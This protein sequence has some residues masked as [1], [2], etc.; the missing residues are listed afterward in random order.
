MIGPWSSPP[1][2]QP[3]P[4][5]PEVPMG[6]GGTGGVIDQ[7]IGLVRETP[8]LFE[9]PPAPAAGEHWHL[10][11]QPHDPPGGSWQ[12][13]GNCVDDIGEGTAPDMVGSDPRDQR[14]GAVP[15]FGWG[16]PLPP[17][18]QPQPQPPPPPLEMAEVDGVVNG[19]SGLLGEPVEQPLPVPHE[20]DDEHEGLLV[21]VPLVAPLRYG[22]GARAGTRGKDSSPW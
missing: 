5:D 20:L 9:G 1:P 10:L 2:P 11:W 13:V 16:G 17:P 3:E 22:C 18:L 14:M 19:L 21:E 12:V 7:R 8:P 4:P 6:E 15:I